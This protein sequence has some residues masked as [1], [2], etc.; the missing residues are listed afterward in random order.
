VNKLSVKE[1]DIFANKI[2]EDYD[3]KNPGVIFKEKKIITNEDALLIQSNVA[4]LREKRGEKV[5][6]YKIGCV[7]K[8]TQKKMGFN[9]PACG[10]LW[11]SEL[12]ASGVELNKK[13]YTNPAMEAEFGVILNRDI[14]P[15]L[16][17][18]DYILQSIEGIYP[19]IEIHNLVFYGNEPY[20]A[21]LLTNNAIHAGVILGSE[22][23]LPSDKT[24][25]DL[26]LIYDQEVI[27]TWTNKIW[28][29]DML[30]EIEWLVKEQSKK[31]NY[32]KK[33]DLI[34][35]GAYGFPVPIN[36]KKLV[37]VTSSAFGDVIATFD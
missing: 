3:F 26:K 25:T 9:Q 19:L 1:L 13:D 22:T 29:N 31:N 15:D 4:R 10:Y 35:T 33:G 6:G 36:D 27:D 8:D 28:P 12:Y 16:A 7:S 11:K 2:L 18:F 34:L 14:K 30:S 32:L 20:G 23:K 24:K 21:E 37:E 5:I 17:S